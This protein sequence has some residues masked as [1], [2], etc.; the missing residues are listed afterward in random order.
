MKK[1]MIKPVLFM[2]LMCFVQHISRAQKIDL[3]WIEIAD[4][5]VVVHYNLQDDNN[6]HEYLVNLFSSQDNFT[7]ELT[8]VSGDIGTEVKPGMGKK[9]VW[10]ITKELG[11]FKGNL[12]FE[13]RARVFIP[14]VKF[15]G[16]NEGQVFKRGK[17]YP[18]TWTSGNMSSQVNI[19]LYK[20]DQRISGDNN[21]PNVGKFDWYVPG[22]AKKGNDYKL[23]FTNVKDRNDVAYSLPFT[24]K[25]K[26]PF[27]FKVLGIGVI[28]GGAVIMKGLFGGDST[29][30]G[31]T[32][33][34]LVGPPPPPN[35]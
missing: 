15:K 2:L 18:I 1:I 23:K 14:F 27:F 16:I 7:K 26:V 25:P 28:G 17:N 34:G 24:I 5:K 13:V 4:N 6:S 12:T 21:Q 11:T 3:D 22:S 31:A 30:G 9:A 29:G 33:S 8:K 32:I 20:G 10:D 35:N 19:E